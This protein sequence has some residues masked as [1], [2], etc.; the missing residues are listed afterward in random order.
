MLMPGDHIAADAT[1]R[2]RYRP[3]HADREEA[4]EVLKAAFVQ[5]RLTREE[6]GARV[7]QAFTSPTHAELTEVTADLPAGLT[8]D[9]APRQLT[10]TRPRLSM[11]AAFA[12]GAFA[13]LAARVGMLAAIASDSKIGVICAAVSIAVVAALIFVAAIA[14]SWPGRAR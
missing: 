14:A 8:G 3:S 13:M 7:G 10:R 9:R 6:L 12:A 1:A 5:G 4:I 11:K 2:G